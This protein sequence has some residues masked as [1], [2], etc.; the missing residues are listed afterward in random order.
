MALEWIYAHSYWSY[1]VFH[2]FSRL[3]ESLVLLLVQNIEML[4][5]R[6]FCSCYSG[7]MVSVVIGGYCYRTSRWDDVLCCSEGV[8]AL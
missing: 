6:L 1:E 4:S 3:G 7:R 5:D 8:V 2:C